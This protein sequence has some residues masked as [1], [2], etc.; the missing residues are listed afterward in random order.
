MDG[1]REIYV[2]K[3]EEA[4]RIAAEVEEPARQH[5]LALANGWRELAAQTARLSK[6]TAPQS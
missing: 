3:A 2:S 4:E 1:Y 6:S 5:W